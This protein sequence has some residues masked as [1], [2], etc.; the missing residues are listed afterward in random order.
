[1]IELSIPGTGSVRLEHLVCDVNGTVAVDGKL[2]EGASR[3]IGVLKDR[4]TIHLLTANTFGSQA[5]IDQQ[6]NLTAI[7]LQQGDEAQQKA[8]YVQQL[9]P[10]RVIAIGQ[11]QMMR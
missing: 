7:R 8:N 4:L 5:V 6:L 3:A 9:G 11:G 10:E 1:M 2:V